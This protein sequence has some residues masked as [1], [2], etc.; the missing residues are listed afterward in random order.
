MNNGPL[1]DEDEEI[2]PDEGWMATFADM[3]LLLLV[4]FILLYSLS[5][6]DP[7]KFTESFGSIKGALGGDSK[8]LPPVATESKGDQGAL[9]EAVKMRKAQIEAQKETFNEIRSYLTRNGV[10]GQVGAV[11]D[12]GTITLRLPANILFGRFQENLSPESHKVLQV[13]QE[14]FVHRREQQI[15]VRGYTDSEAPPPGMRFKDNWELSALRAVSVLRYLLAQ[16]IEASRL[17]AT[18]FGDLE[19][20]VPNTTAENRTRNR[21]VEFVLQRRVMKG[22]K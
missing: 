15:D 4:F 18:G 6:L 14:I 20:L 8:G 13:L 16:G 3:S 10:E 22:G 5:T 7:S 12:E 21:R 9:H 19:P 2:T 1:Q 11:L 17:T